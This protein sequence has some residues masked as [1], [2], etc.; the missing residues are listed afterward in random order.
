MVKSSLIRPKKGGRRI[1]CKECGISY[2]GKQFSILFENKKLAY[3]K[4]RIPK[5]RRVKTLCHG[6]LFTQVSKYCGKK[7]FIKI[8]KRKMKHASEDFWETWEKENL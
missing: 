5:T 7:D 3:F 1:T 4:L 8:K 2:T 6:C